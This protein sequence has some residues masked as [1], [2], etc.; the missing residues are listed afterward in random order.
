MN[1]LFVAQ[2]FTAELSTEVI[3]GPG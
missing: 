2:S 3:T 1:T